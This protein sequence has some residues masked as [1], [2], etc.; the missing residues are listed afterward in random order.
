V[1]WKFVDTFVQ[2][3]FLIAK[4]KERLKQRRMDEAVAKIK[5]V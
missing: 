2:K 3:S 1:W 5:F 4:V